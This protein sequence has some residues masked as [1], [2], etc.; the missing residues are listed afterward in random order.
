MSLLSAS[1]VRR[2]TSLEVDRITSTR[3][4][5]TQHI[6][7][8]PDQVNQAIQ[9]AA[10]VLGVARSALG[11][12]CASR[13]AVYGPLLYR[14]APSA[15]WL[16][17][18]QCPRSISGDSRA[19]AR[20]A[21]DSAARHAL[22]LQHLAA[23]LCSRDLHNCIES[24]KHGGAICIAPSQLVLTTDLELDGYPAMMA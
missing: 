5:K 8:S 4:V 2:C 1:S 19:F 7:S 11:I 16:D 23:T 20:L 9:E 22:Q 14:D 3:R 18:S 21:F 10:A 24:L 12:C 6:F 15:P 13:G 17:C